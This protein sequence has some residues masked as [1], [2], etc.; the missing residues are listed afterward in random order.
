MSRRV[1]KRRSRRSPSPTDESSDEDAFTH[2]QC[3]IPAANIDLVVLATYLR[4]FI[5]DTA[6]IKTAANPQVNRV[7]EAIMRLQLIAY[8]ILP[9][10]AFR[11]V[12]E[13]H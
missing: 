3:W 2:I 9:S 13:I 11:L 8:R 10:P 7:L 12:L 4:E 6:T 5:D 1:D